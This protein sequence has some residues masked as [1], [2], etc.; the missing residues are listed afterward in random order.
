MLKLDYSQT[1]WTVKAHEMEQMKAAVKSAHQ[2]LHE[3][4]GAGNDFLGWIQLPVNYD[5]EE[6]ARIKKAAEQIRKDSDVLS[7]S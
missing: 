2:T 4:T 6:F 5:K 3:A 1:E 7:G